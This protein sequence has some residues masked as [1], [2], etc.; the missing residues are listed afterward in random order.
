ML[1]FSSGDSMD[2]RRV[3]EEV[4]RAASRRGPS[5]ELSESFEWRGTLGDFQDCGDGRDARQAMDLVAGE[6]DDGHGG[7]GAHR[8][9][10]LRDEHE[11]SGSAASAA[12]ASFAA[13]EDDGSCHALDVPLEGAADGLV[14]IIDVEDKAAVG[15]LEGAEIEDVRVSAELGKYRLQCAAGRRGQR[16]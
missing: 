3:G 2:K 12:D 14:E 16:P 6:V 9:A 11:C 5:V 1:G 4:A 15:C 8:T 10:V 13:G 7:E